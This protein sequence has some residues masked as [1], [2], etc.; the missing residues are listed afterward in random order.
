[1]VRTGVG[2]P[3]P[4]ALPGKAAALYRPH[5]LASDEPADAIT[6]NASI[7][8]SIEFRGDAA[9]VTAR[10]GG[11]QLQSLD[12]LGRASRVSLELSR[13]AGTGYLYLAGEADQVTVRRPAGVG[14]GFNAQGGLTRLSIDGQTFA[15]LERNS[16]RE[17]PDMDRLPA[18]YEISIA[19][20]GS[21]VTIEPQNDR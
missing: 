15:S 12:V 3:Y 11:V 18:R 6:L 14:V 1:M 19:S 20:R 21:R 2:A 8:W 5:F 9:R 10:L 4:L 16:R 17:T 7:P 13:P